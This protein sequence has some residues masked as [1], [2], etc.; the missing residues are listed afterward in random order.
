MTSRITERPRLRLL[1][2]SVRKVRDNPRWGVF[3]ALWVTS[4]E[5]CELAG[6]FP[7]DVKMLRPGDEFHVPGNVRRSTYKGKVQYRVHDKCAPTPTTEDLRLLLQLRPLGLTVGGEKELRERAV[8]DDDDDDSIRGLLV[9]LPSAASLVTTHRI[10]RAVARRIFTFAAGLREDR[11]RRF[12]SFLREDDLPFCQRLL[13]RA[14]TPA[15][16]AGTKRVRDDGSDAHRW[17]DAVEEDPYALARAARGSQVPRALRLAE[18]F[19]AALGL[20]ARDARRV[21]FHAGRAFR[22]LTWQQGHTW[23]PLVRFET[24]IRTHLD[25]H[26]ALFRRDNNDDD[27][28]GDLGPDFGGA[29]VRCCD[30]DSG[31]PPT[32]TLV[33]LRAVD[34][35]ERSLAAALHAIR[36]GP[37]PAPRAA[38]AGAG[39]DV[40][41]SGSSSIRLSEEQDQAATRLAQSRVA[42]LTGGAGTGKTTVLRHVL[43]RVDPSLRRWLLAPTGKAAARMAEALGGDEPTSTIHR[44]IARLEHDAMSDEDKRAPCVVVVDEVSM[45]TPGL[46][47]RLLRRLGDATRQLLLVGDPNQLPSIEPGAL[48]RDVIA[49]GMGTVVTLTTVFR[50]SSDAGAQPVASVAASVAAG[51]VRPL[52]DAHPPMLRAERNLKCAIDRAVELATETLRTHAGRDMRHVLQVLTRTNRVR[53]Q[54][55]ERMRAIHNPAP[56]AGGATTPQLLVRRADDDDDWTYRR[57]D[58]VMNVTNHYEE[59]GAFLANGT[60]GVVQRVRDRWSVLVRFA[61]VAADHAGWVFSLRPGNGHLDVREHLRPAYALTVH[62]FQGSETERAVCIVEGW[63]PSRNWLYTAMTRG[64]RQVDLLDTEGGSAVRACVRT[65]AL[66]RITRL[67]ERIRWCAPRAPSPLPSPSRGKSARR[68]DSAPAPQGAPARR[69]APPVAPPAAAPPPAP[70]AP[71]EKPA[72]SPRPFPSPAPCAAPTPP[73]P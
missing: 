61:G 51:D 1:S 13:L 44:L 15:S 73:H 21:R 16:A 19:A 60:L 71:P 26:G 4:N 41:T 55:N 72:S 11:T 2:S 6:T 18:Q 65:P 56:A 39:A 10:S 20:T 7:W 57:G 17:L 36:A 30:D 31:A 14:D 25:E 22:S 46:L 5:R 66:R 53:R 42:V 40:T 33:T 58:L 64:K 27:D 68:A 69:S 24:E 54:L 70:C 49:S 62:K 67:A 45:V 12:A 63:R 29:M 23:V 52:L 37:A 34:D 47:L 59:G 43:A 8:T 50:Q 32:T 35:E 48:L 9:R 28:A 38:D 3:R